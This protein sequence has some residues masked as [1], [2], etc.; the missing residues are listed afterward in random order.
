MAVL[1]A[2]SRIAH[3]IGDTNEEEVEVAVTD[4]GRIAHNIGDTNEEEVEVAVTGDGRIAHHIGDTNEEEMEMELAM[5][6]HGGIV[7]HITD[8]N[9]EM[10][11]DNGSSLLNLFLSMAI[12]TVVVVL[13]G[14]LSIAEGLSV[15][16]KR[17]SSHVDLTEEPDNK[18]Q[19]TQSD[20]VKYK[21]NKRK[22]TKVAVPKATRNRIEF[23]NDLHYKAIKT[24]GILDFFASKDGRSRSSPWDVRSMGVIQYL[25]MHLGFHPYKFKQHIFGQLYLAHFTSE[26]IDSKVRTLMKMSAKDSVWL[27]LDSREF[28]ERT[29]LVERGAPRQSVF[30]TH[31]HHQLYPCAPAYDGVTVLAE[32]TL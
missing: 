21:S 12:T 5:T 1:S 7:H 15:S 2:N 30:Q 10:V 3:N 6:G 29:E 26:Q 4:D 13:K 16:N 24:P 28:E 17:K 9:E 22:R 23:E 14:A 31:R 18:R 11:F 19:H 20:A 25:L 27:F 8:T 32:F